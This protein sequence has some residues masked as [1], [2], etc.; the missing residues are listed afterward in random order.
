LPEWY[1]AAVALAAEFEVEPSMPRRCGRQ[2]Q[3][4]NVEAK[5]PEEYY[6]RALAIPLLDGMIS[7]FKEKFAAQ[8]S[9]IR[10]GSLLVPGLFLSKFVV[11]EAAWIAEVKSFANVYTKFLPNPSALEEDARLWRR[12]WELLRVQVGASTFFP[13]F[14]N[15]ILGSYLEVMQIFNIY[16]P[17]PYA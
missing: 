4:D 12:K 1:L 6:R 8:K 5:T 11:S 13:C 15:A 17:L 10:G 7:E 16:K 3:R 14:P 2:T 9:I